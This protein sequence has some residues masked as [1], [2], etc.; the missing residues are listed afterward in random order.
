MDTKPIAEIAPQKMRASGF[1]DWTMPPPFN[2]FDHM[3]IREASPTDIPTIKQLLAQLGYPDLNEA[4]VVK[5]IANYQQ[6]SYKLLVSEDESRVTGFIALHTFDIFHSI[7]RIGRITAFCV[8]EN[9]RG[10]GI[11]SRLME[12]AEA[13]FTAQGCTKLEVTSNERR[14]ATHAYY[15]NKGWTEDSRRFVK[16]L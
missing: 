10:T 12:A 6:A 9:I 16:Y 8:D 3:A 15:K 7:G 5:K 14:T 13:W 2:N 11:G 1:G 4:D